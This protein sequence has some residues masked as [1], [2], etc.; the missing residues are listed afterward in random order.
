M[1]VKF[2][3]GLILSSISLRTQEK[4]AISMKLVSR[5]QTSISAQGIYCLQYKRPCRKG[6]GPV[7]SADSFSTRSLTF[8]YTLGVDQIYVMGNL[9]S[10]RM[11]A[12]I[13][14]SVGIAN[15]I[16]ITGFFTTNRA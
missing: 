8:V 3:H 2:L 6:S 13:V 7:H 9:K 1:H 14:E 12:L 4:E 10:G 5:G 16:L 11:H 15:H